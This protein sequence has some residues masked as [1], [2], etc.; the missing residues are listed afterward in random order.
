MTPILKATIVTAALFISVPVIASSDGGTGP[1]EEKINQLIIYGN[2]EC[3]ASTNNEIT[4]CVILVEGERFRIPENLR[5]DPNNIRNEA[6]AQKVVGYRY[7]GASGTMSC[8]PTGAGGFTGCGLKEIDKAYAEKQ[9]DPGLSFG[10]LIAEERNKRLAGIDAEA[11]QV[12]ERVKQFEK[13]RAEKEAR[14]AGV[15]VPS[16]D[17]SIDTG[18]LPE[19]E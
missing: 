11:D 15:M 4:V 19:P 18:P 16:Q 2:D 17:E 5:N 1:G 8:S 6:W 3:P 9:Q 13:E 7:V 14:Q 12:E 10:R